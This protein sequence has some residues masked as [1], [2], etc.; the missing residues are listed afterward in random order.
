M[1]SHDAQDGAA[2]SDDEAA[3]VGRAIELALTLPFAI[4]ARLVESAPAGIARFVGKLAVDRGAREMRD[5]LGGPE[6]ASG[7]S[8]SA[9]AK[10]EV[11]APADLPAKSEGAVESPGAEALA[12][13][14]YDQLP[15]AHV[16]AKLASLSKDEREALEAYEAAHR[17]RRTVLGKLAQLRADEQGA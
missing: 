13:P 6:R 3:P 11:V 2:I 1:T 8:A 15:A 10:S 7:K 12:L 17:H 9:N 5:R 14:D 4:G 16:V